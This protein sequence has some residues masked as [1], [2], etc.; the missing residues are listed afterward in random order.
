MGDRANLDLVGRQEEL[1]RALIATGKPVIALLFNGAPLSVTYLSQNAAAVV[2]CWYL[3][4][5]NGR[6]VAEILFGDYNPGGKLPITIPRSV[7]QVPVFYNYKPSARRG[8]LFDDVTPLYP[9]G[10]GLSYTKF[11]IGNIRLTKKRISA[12]GSTRV[13]ADVTNTGSREGTETVQMYIRDLVSS[14]TRPVKELKG[15]ERV[16]L[17]PGESKTVAFDI[18]PESLAFYDVNMKYVVEP[19]EFEVMVGSSS[20]DPDL[21]KIILRVQ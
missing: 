9:F 1:A 10:F 15:F 13:L 12:R 21:Q 17:R 19:G 18:T 5:E 3:G 7:G 20:R 4:Q 11:E 16:S 14:V 2:E 8:F 6:A